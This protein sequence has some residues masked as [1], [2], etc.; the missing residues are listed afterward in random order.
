MGER[1]YWE[2]DKVCM[3][4]LRKKPHFQGKTLASM[5]AMRFSRGRTVRDEVAK[6]AETRLFWVFESREKVWVLF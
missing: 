5:E 2:E 1:A 6:N 3:K 4:A